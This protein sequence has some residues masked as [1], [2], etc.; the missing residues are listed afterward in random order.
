MIDGVPENQLPSK[1]RT[2]QVLFH[3]IAYIQL[4]AHA[5]SSRGY[6]S[7][8]THYPTHADRSR[9]CQLCRKQL[10]D[11]KNRSIYTHAHQVAVSWVQIISFHFQP[12]EVVTATY[13][14]STFK[15]APKPNMQCALPLCQ[16]SAVLLQQ[17]TT[18]Q[19]AHQQSKPAVIVTLLAACCSTISAKCIGSAA[20]VTVPS[21][22]FAELPDTDILATKARLFSP[23]ACTPA[24]L[25]VPP[26]IPLMHNMMQAT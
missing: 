1:N 3:H 26:P 15:R 21:A 20:P 13:D 25:P 9:T 18:H 7:Q 24:F 8:E 16:H 12:L 14:K 2:A 10:M 11:T 23:L 17:V 5:H 19:T 6:A 22:A 4:T